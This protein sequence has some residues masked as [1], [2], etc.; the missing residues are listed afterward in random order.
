MIIKTYHSNREVTMKL[1]KIPNPI[2]LLASCFLILL[3]GCFALPER[4]L[5]EDELIT[6]FNS[7]LEPTKKLSPLETL[8]VQVAGLA[9]NQYHSVKVISAD[10]TVISMIEVKSNAEGV[11]EPT[12][13]WYDIGLKNADSTHNAPWIDQTSALEL[14]AFY[15]RVQSIENSD[16]DFRQEMF[17]VYGTSDASAKPRPV[18]SACYFPNGA[19]TSTDECRFE[20]AFEETGSRESDGTL[21]AKTRVWVK[22]HSIPATIAGTGTAVSKVDVYILPFTGTTLDNDDSLENYVVRKT[23]VSVTTDGLTKT[24]NPT[25]LWDLNVQQLINPGEGTSTYRVVIDVDRDGKFD[26]GL[27]LNNDGVTDQYIDGVKGDSVAGFVV[28]NTPANDLIYRIE[29]DNSLVLNSLMESGDTTNLYL[30]MDNVPTSDTT[31]DI[32]IMN[33]STLAD[34]EDLTNDVRGQKSTATITT[35][36]SDDVRYL[37]YIGHVKILDTQGSTAYSYRANNGDVSADIALDVVVDV[38][39]DG[40]FDKGTDFFLSDK[41]NILAVPPTTQIKTCGTLACTTERRIFDETN[42]TN[43][44]T[45]VYLQVDITGAN[46]T[47]LTAY[48]F[49]SRKWNN[50]D[51]LSGELLSVVDGENTPFSFWDIDDSPKVINPKP[52]DNTYDVLIDADNDGIYNGNDNSSDNHDTLITIVIRDTSANSFPKV[53]YANIASG[54]FYKRSRNHWSSK[55]ADMDY[56]D[57]FRADGTDTKGIWQRHNRRWK[58]RYGI[59]STWNPYFKWWRNRNSSTTISGLYYRKLVDVYIVNAETIDLSNWS[60]ITLSDSLDVTGR[61]KTLPVQYSCYN[62]AGQQLIWEAPMT[63]GKYHVIVDV[64]RNGKIDEGVDIIDA[65]NKAGKTIRDDS[66][67]VGFS[68]VN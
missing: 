67:I 48:L 61:K 56:R 59:K 30:S 12:P 14:R 22:A 16:T 39:R 63:V 60:S 9:K 25:L 32:Y 33:T 36:A 51:Y 35:P 41:L 64:N 62:G 21:T 31:A 29:D 26:T 13:L 8:H 57:V 38:D 53:N 34:Q 6:I 55:V 49:K 47:N 20:N 45:H 11:I 18:V 68:V 17:I 46:P 52:G 15:V 4:E 58:K 5:P 3:A 23:G 28:Q 40:K 27:D 10:G 50:G 43:G 19:N 44:N 54:G 7:S 1:K 37:P 66:S 24:L 65:V 42:T 2:V